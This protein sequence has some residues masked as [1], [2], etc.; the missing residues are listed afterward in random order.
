M[1]RCIGKRLLIIVM[2]HN[3]SIAASYWTND[4]QPGFGRLA[5]DHAR[6][7]ARAAHAPA[8]RA[9][10]PRAASSARRARRSAGRAS[11]PRRRP[12]RAS[13]AAGSAAADGARATAAARAAN[14][15]TTTRAPAAAHGRSRVAATGSRQHVFPGVPGAPEGTDDN[16]NTE[17]CEFAGAHLPLVSRAPAPHLGKCSRRRCAARNPMRQRPKRGH[18]QSRPPDRV[19]EPDLD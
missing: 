3:C 7:R 5:V 12:R 10:T 15:S 1:S 16:G 14:V 19:A 13:A 17:Q 11:A 2:V 4:R 6:A 8:S 9:A 18:A